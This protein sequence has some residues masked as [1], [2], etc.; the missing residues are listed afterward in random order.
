M[1][2]NTLLTVVC[3]LL[4]VLIGQLAALRNLLSTPQQAGGVFDQTHPGSPM[5]V[6]IVA[7][8]GYMPVKI[9]SDSNTKESDEDKFRNEFTRDIRAMQDKVKAEIT[10]LNEA[11]G[12]VADSSRTHDRT[13]YQAFGVAFCETESSCAPVWVSKSINNE[14]SS[15]SSL[16]Y[17]LVAMLPIVKDV[18][19]NRVFAEDP[20]Q[21]VPRTVGAI[22]VGERASR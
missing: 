22:L 4:L 19:S 12:S 2:K 11:R 14:L 17:R 7:Q 13:E 16:G 6:R 3:L 8:T 9:I 1:Y 20:H 5:D 10:L 15:M 18:E 21:I